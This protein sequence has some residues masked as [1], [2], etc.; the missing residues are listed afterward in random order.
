MKYLYI[1]IALLVFSSCEKELELKAPSELTVAGFWDSENGV[2]AAHTG[3]YGSFRGTNNTQWLLGEIRSDMYGGQTFESPANVE[4]IESN[5]TVSTAPFGGWAGLYSEIHKVNDFL[6]NVPNIEFNN[7]ADKKHML[8]QAYGIRALYYYTL[9]KTWGSVPI[10]TE[11][12]ATTDPQGLSKPRAPQSEVMALIKADIKA[13]LDS[14]GSDA[15]FWLDKRV[16]W[17]KAATLTLKGDV[18]IWSGT[19]LE[20]GNADYTEAK[21]ALQEVASLDVELVPNFADLWSIDNE[22][23]NEFIFAFQYEQDQET[24]FYSSLTGRTTEIQPQ[25]DSEGNSLSDFIVNGANR[26]G[27]SEK[28]LTLTD[29]NLDTRKDATFIRLYTDDNGGTGYPTYTPDKYFGSVIKKFDGTV[30]GSIRIMDNDVPIYRYADV[31]LLLAEAKNLLGEDPSV[32]INQIRERAY[33]EN[34]DVATNGYIN[35]SQAQ[36]TEAILE[37][38]YKEFVAEGKRWWDL[39]RAGNSYVI[40]NVPFLSTG[41]EYKLLLPITLDMIGRNPLLEQT[42]GYN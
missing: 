31:L 35:A 32:E 19:L 22:N 26:Y 21:N 18:Y 36:N 37:E 1:I 15:S 11:P 25:F 5:I 41:E 20:G 42:P 39:R 9:L 17:S 3:L 4:L 16:Y 14:F 29:D 27:P 40:D 2:R 12:L 24:N 10:T 13:S 30:D 33:A 34:Y 6:L 38:R 28:T 23:N 7:E 8:G